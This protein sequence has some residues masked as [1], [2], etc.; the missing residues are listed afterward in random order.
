MAI[1]MKGDWENWVKFFLRGVQETARMANQAALEIHAIHQ[2]DSE[3]VRSTRANSSVSQ[4]YHAFCKFPIATVSELLKI[5]PESNAMTI[6][7]AIK[8]L[9]EKKIVR[10]FG[11]QKR[12]RRFVYDEYMKILTRD[13]TSQ[14]G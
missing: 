9:M 5:I 6:N 13:T 2:R 8:I 12:N 4:V 7:R 11:T 3:I 14:I 1:R 10:Q